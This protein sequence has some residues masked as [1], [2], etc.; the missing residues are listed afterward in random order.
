M[1]RRFVMVILA[2][3][4]V[5]SLV[6]WS[7]TE[8]QKP[9]NVRLIDVDFGERV[10]IVRSLLGV[11]DGPLSEYGSVDLSSYY[12]DLGGTHVRL[13]DFWGAVDINQVFPEMDADSTVP[14]SYDF[15]QTD[16]YLR[17]INSIG[18]RSSIVW[19]IVGGSACS[20]CASGGLREVGFDLCSR[21]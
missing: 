4:L 15:W 20:C 2:V 3:V 14:E 7:F 5:S 1:S 17:A 11:N 12:S 10:G 18:L 9:R 13:H 8:R 19:G 6:V 21:D 16:M